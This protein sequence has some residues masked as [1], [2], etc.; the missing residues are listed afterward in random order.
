METKFKVTI[1]GFISRPN[2]PINQW[3]KDPKVM[4]V[5]LHVHPE[6]HTPALDGISDREYTKLLRKVARVTLAKVTQDIPNDPDLKAM[7][8]D[9][10]YWD[11]LAGCSCGCSPGFVF[12][13]TQAKFTSWIDIRVEESV[14]EEVVFS[15]NFS[16]DQTL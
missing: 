8:E 13:S 7:A 3:K 5:R 15:D 1:L 11:R 6:N 9:K 10:F 12:E 16:I 4:K 14:T 2:D